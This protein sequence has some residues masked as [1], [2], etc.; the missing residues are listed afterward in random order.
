M[1]L[2]QSLERLA[3]IAEAQ[4]LKEKTDRENKERAKAV[5]EEARR[6]KYLGL[7]EPACRQVELIESEVNKDARIVDWFR[8]RHIVCLGERDAR[9]F[10]YYLGY[11]ASSKDGNDVFSGKVNLLLNLNNYQISRALPDH[12]CYR[13]GCVRASQKILM[14]I[15]EEGWF[16]DG[17]DLYGLN[18]LQGLLVL[19]VND[20]YSALETAINGGFSKER[21][22][23]IVVVGGM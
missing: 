19:S 4:V 1:A 8:N 6:Q 22:G 18:T 13:E 9:G 7:V 5:E 17:S 15:A 16:F 21:C 12:A 20:F 2:T 10:P 14:C 11:V 23:G 3:Q